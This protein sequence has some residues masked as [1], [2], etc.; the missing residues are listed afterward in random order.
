MTELDPIG[1]DVKVVITSFGYGHPD[2]PP[3]ADITFDARRRFRNPHADPKM[4]DLN[5]KDCAVLAH[6][7]ETPGVAET[8]AC[9]AMFAAQFSHDLAGSADRRALVAIGCSGGRHRSVVIA[10]VL[11]EALNRMGV[12][13]WVVHRDIDKPVL[14]RH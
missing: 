4:I 7:M 2:P 12:R 10:D 8:I 3:H 11:G 14:G 1:A 6:V 13:A 5:G 9:L